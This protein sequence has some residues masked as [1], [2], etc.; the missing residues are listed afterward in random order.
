MFNLFKEKLFP[1]V[2]SKDEQN[3]YK[4]LLKSYEDKNGATIGNDQ[5]ESKRNADEIFAGYLI[6]FFELTN[7]NY[8]NFLLKFVILFRECL[9]YYKTLPNF[10]E[11]SQEN[12]ADSAPDLCNEF[13]TEFMENNDN[14]GLDPNEL[15]DVIQHFCFWL[16]ENRHTTSRL[17]LMS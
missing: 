13:I 7:K 8:Y 14:Y 9:N 3:F 10:N 15:I 2:N 1:N 4:I 16:Y 12:G 17:T 11:Y 5:N 6:E